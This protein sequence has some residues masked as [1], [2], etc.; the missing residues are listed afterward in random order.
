MKKFYVTIEKEGS[1]QLV[2]Y[3]RGE[4][5]YDACFSYAD[6]YLASAGAAPISLSFP[7]TEKPYSPAAT[8]SFFEGL[9]PEGFTRRAVAQ[10]LRVDAADYLPLLHG[11]G[12]EC[13]GALAVLETEELPGSAYTPISGQEVRALAAEG[14][15]RSAEI[16]TRTHL[17]LTGASGKAGLYLDQETGRWYL[18]KGMAASTHIV[19]QSHI[20]LDGIVT[21]EQL[22]LLTARRCGIEIPESFIIDT[23]HG[24]EGEVLFATKRYDRV[25][26]PGVPLVSGL[27]CP[28]R[29]HQED[30]AQALGIPAEEK[31]E[32]GR[33][34]YLKRMFELLRKYSSD[35]IADQLKL[36]DDL[37]FDVLIGNTDAHLK[38]FSLLYSADLKTVRLAPAYDIVSTVAYRESTREMAVTIGDAEVLDDITE[39]TLMMA[40]GEAGIG[41]RIARR[42]FLEIKDKFR[43]AL[44]TSACD[45]NAAGYPKALE[46]E[47]RILADRVI[48]RIHQ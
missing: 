46:L 6:S 37:V 16:V 45:L 3:I 8:R 21:N 23:G 12:Q 25:F 18:P 5:S 48:T 41:E 24:A 2:G 39:D 27:P 47:Q 34:G 44:H 9:L 42:R 13:L 1:R 7:L 40:A 10:W 22:S 30:F 19:K 29:L 26:G 28:R 35:P 11:L 43:E 20:R 32:Q 15:T 36:W 4:N 14:A 17:S 33:T 31:Y 38:N